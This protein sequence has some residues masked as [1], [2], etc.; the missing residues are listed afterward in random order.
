MEMLRAKYHD[1]KRG[2]DNVK[3]LERIYD[4]KEKRAEDRERMN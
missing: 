2:V 1:L 4:H 3:Y